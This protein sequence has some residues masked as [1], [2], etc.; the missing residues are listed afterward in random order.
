[1][2]AREMPRIAD[3]RRVDDRR[4]RRA[5]D[6][7]KIRD[8]EAAALHLLERQLPVACFLGQLRQLHGELHDVLGVGV[9]DDRHEQPAI[10]VHG[11]AD[12]DV[13]LL[14][15][16]FRRHVD[17]DVEL[18]EG[19]QR[20]RDH[21]HGDRGDRQIAAGGLHLLRVVLAKLFER[22][23]VGQIVL[24]HMWNG[25][26]RGRQ[27]L[28]RLAP[29]AAHRQPFDLAPSAEVGQRL[30]AGR[31]GRRRADE[32]IDVRFHIFGR[33]AAAASSAGHVVDVDAK[34]ARHAA[35]GRRRRRRRQLGLGRR[36]GGRTA[37]AADIDH[38]LGPGRAASRARRRGAGVIRRLR[39]FGRAGLRGVRLAPA[40]RAGSGRRALP[41]DGLARARRLQA[42]P[43]R[44]VRQRPPGTRFTAAAGASV[45][46][47]AIVS[48]A[49]AVFCS[50]LAAA[51]PTWRL[52]ARA[53]AAA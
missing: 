4:E 30:R 24:R 42:R 48:V 35:Y 1:M 39:L 3:F 28:G 11:D 17:R 9:A 47:G 33:N 49:L 19:L 37:A 32:A 20:R 13:L 40:S 29:Y 51:Y 31:A 53:C 34:L 36:F 25:R 5:A 27:V 6:A 45:P 14:D 12:V 46:G 2:R 43:R 26:P 7:A 52:I 15:D 21:L 44:L 22:R 23:D 8:A 50:G 41:L 10:G 18:R 16:F 38:L